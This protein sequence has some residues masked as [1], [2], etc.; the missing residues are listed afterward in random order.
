MFSLPSYAVVP[1]HIRIAKILL[2]F[3]IV[4][5]TYFLLVENKERSDY[6]FITQLCCGRIRICLE[7]S[8]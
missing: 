6:V 8:M 1:L 7:H 3:H 4:L 2:H 5:V